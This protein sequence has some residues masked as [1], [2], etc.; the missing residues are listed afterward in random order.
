V[1]VVRAPQY[2]ARFPARELAAQVRTATPAGES[3]LSLLGDYDFIIAFYLDRPLAP[4]PGPPELLAARSPDRP[5]YA[6]IDEDDRAV[7]QAPRVTAL[8]HGQL[9]PKRIVLVRL[10]PAPR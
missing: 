3:I 2:E 6:L 7:L 9:G 5:R 4:L 8:A 1:A 10:D